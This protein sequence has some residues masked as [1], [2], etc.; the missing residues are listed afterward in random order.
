MLQWRTVL[1]IAV[2]AV[3]LAGFGL[4]SQR[5]GSDLHVGPVPAQ[6]GYY[7]K[8]AVVTE[9]DATGAPRFKLRAQ[10]I[11]QNPKDESVDL[12]TVQLDYRSD[13][14]SLW[15]LTADHGHL[16]GGSRVIDFTGN[17]NIKPQAPSDNLIELQTETLSMDTEHN[18]ATAPGKVIFKMDQQVLNAVGLKYNLKRQKLQLESGLHGQF[19]RQ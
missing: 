11:N 16:V 17:V 4:W 1:L 3:I 6:P 13:P 14:D 7:L 18:I 15:L 19:K 9:T 2:I 12:Q 10:Q 8:D 5:D